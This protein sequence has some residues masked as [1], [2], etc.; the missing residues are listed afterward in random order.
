MNVTLPNGKIIRGVPEGTSKDQIRQ[1]AISSG[2][3]TA[4]DFGQAPQPQSP[5]VDMAAIRKQ[6][7]DEVAAE[8]GPLDALMIGAGKGFYDVGRG[9]G[10][11]DSESESDAQ[12][13]D[14]LREQRPYTTGAGEI[15]GQAAPFIPLGMGAAAGAKFLPGMAGMGGQVVA[16]GAVGAGEGAVLAN[17]SGQ[18]MVSGASIGASV[19]SGAEIL[20]PVLGRLGRSLYRKVTGKMPSGSMLDGAGRPTAELQSA[21]DEAGLSIDDLTGD[22]EA[23]IRN[24]Q[25]N[26][27]PRQLATAARFSDEGIPVSK[28]ELMQGD[29]SFEQRT[30]ESRMLESAADKQAEKFRQFKLKQ[31]NAIRESMERSV[32]LDALPENTGNLIKDA[33]SDRKALLRTQKNVL[34]SQALSAVDNVSEL[35]L[36]VDNI[37]KTLPDA[38]ALRGMNRAS[39][40]KI[41]EV[42]DTMAEYGL[43]PPREGIDAEDILP[44]SLQNFEEF[45]QILKGISRQDQSGATGNFIQPITEAVDDEVANLA[46]TAQG[47]GLS[48]SVIAPLREA[49]QVVK[50]MKEEFNPKA[51]AGKLTDMK[52]NSSEPAVFGSKVYSKLAGRAEPVENVRKVMASLRQ[53]G[54]KGTEAIANLQST[55]MLDLIDAGFSTQSRQIDGIR[56]FNPIAFKRR[57]QALGEDKLDAIFQGNPGMARRIKNMDKIAADLVPPSGAVPKGSTNMIGDLANRLGVMTLNAKFPGI[58][59]ASEWIKKMSDNKGSLRAVR[60]AMDAK[61][62]VRKVINQIDREFPGIAAALGISGIS[63]N[64]NQATDDDPDTNQ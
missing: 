14:A 61:P 27:D 50:Q 52:R 44:L 33:L 22:A 13:M 37:V 56:T 39:G 62:E 5:K 1:K 53:S 38:R 11:L 51:V 10:L 45:N 9:L 31:S 35:P 16:G 42:L 55:T 30:L 28:G 32:N 18:D 25:P 29:A 7:M 57:L 20:F 40:G 34:Y 4:E 46:E 43:V 24:A 41:N 36:M 47:L 3:A 2:L 6:A 23:L 26:T 21:L 63:M 60:D 12:A 17:A 15:A 48:E 54:A 59:V 8:Q 64:S 58:G 19:G 49:R